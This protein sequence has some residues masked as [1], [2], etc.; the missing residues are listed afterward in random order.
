MRIFLNQRREVRVIIRNPA[1]ALLWRP[2]LINLWSA[3]VIS[4]CHPNPS[5]SIASL[6]A[7]PTSPLQAMI[8]SD[9]KNCIYIQFHQSVKLITRDVKF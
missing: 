9:D 2:D 4:V 7:E 8:T 5:N 1:I 3:L 6:S